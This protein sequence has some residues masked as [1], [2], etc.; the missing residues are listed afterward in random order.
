VVLLD[1]HERQFSGDSPPSDAPSTPRG[2]VEP[3]RRLRVASSL[4][5]AVLAVALGVRRRAAIATAGDGVDRIEL[6]ISPESLPFEPAYDCSAGFQNWRQGWAPHKKEWCCNHFGKGC[7][8][9]FDCNSHLDQWESK[10]SSGQKAWCC[11]HEG[12]G[13][14]IDEASK[15]HPYDCNAGFNHWK[16]GWSPFKKEYCCKQVQRG[17]EGKKALPYDC[18]AG[19][20]N[21][22]TGWANEKKKFCCQFSGKGCDPSLAKPAYDCAAGLKRW[23]V[24]WSAP[25]KKWCCEHEKRGCEPQKLPYD[26]NAGFDHWKLGWS[27]PKKA[28]CCQNAMKGCEANLDLAAP[29]PPPPPAPT[30]PPPPYDCGAGLALWREGWSAPKKAWCCKNANKGCDYDC[31]ADFDMWP[32]KWS[33]TKKKWCCANA[34]RG[35]EQCKPR[36]VPPT[37]VPQGERKT[38]AMWGDP[39]LETFD[40]SEVTFV[41]EGVFWLVKSSQVAIQGQYYAT[42]FTKGLSA[43]HDVLV[44]G[45]F[46]YNHRIKVGPMDGG[47][48]EFDGNPILWQFGEFD[49]PGGAGKVVHNAEGIPV[50]HSM[51]NLQKNVVHMW[52]PLGVYVQVMRWSNHLNV[53]ITMPP[54]AGGQDGH[55]G[56]MNNNPDDDTEGQIQQRV[57]GPV[58]NNGESLFHH[59][60]QVHPQREKLTL[61]DCDP[62]RRDEAERLCLQAQPGIV[63]E[64][65]DSCVF[66]VC[67]GGDQY[68]GEDGLEEVEATGFDCEAGYANFKTGWSTVKKEWCCEYCGRGCEPSTTPKIGIT[69]FTGTFTYT[70][71]STVTTTTT[72]ITSTSTT[73][74][75][76]STTFT[77]TTT[78]THTYTT[79]TLTTTTRT[80]ST[81]TITTTTKTTTTS[82]TRTQ[83][84]TTTSTVT[85]TT[86][87]TST[88]TTTIFHCDPQ[89]PV[90]SWSF[91]KLG[92]CCLHRGIGCSTTS[93][94]AFR[95]EG[96]PLDWEPGKQAWCCLSEKIGCATTTQALYDC[97]LGEEH[98]KCGW[99]TA[100]K[101]WCCKNA[102]KACVK[103]AAYDCSED[104]L[105][106]QTKWNNGKKAWCCI[107]VGTGCDWATST[108]PSP[109]F[110]C[111][112]GLRWVDQWSQE[113]KD[114]CCDNEDR[115]CY[116]C[117]HGVDNWEEGWSIGK[118]DW[119]CRNFNLGCVA[120]LG[121]RT[122]T[123]DE[124]PVGVSW[125]GKKA[126][127]C[128]EQAML[129]NAKLPPPYNCHDGYDAVPPRWP[130][131]WPEGKK[132]WC[133]LHEGRG[134]E[135][136][137]PTSTS[138]LLG[139]VVSSMAFDCD[140]DYSQWWKRWSELKQEHC[141]RTQGRGCPGTAPAPPP[142]PEPHPELQMASQ[143]ELHHMAMHSSS[144]A[145]APEET[146]SFD[147]DAGFANWWDGWSM[148]KKSW[149]CSKHQRGCPGTEPKSFFGLWR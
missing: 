149:C 147:C 40:R 145:I 70:Y 50:D 136:D 25:K 81:S 46:I 118:K 75:S 144:P 125:K 139:G 143:P 140:A 32:K 101:E 3:A 73:H 58:P 72:T 133:C 44:S 82:T 69:F 64:F 86:T 16:D 148:E 4:A 79:S 88:S 138:C 109:N 111:D 22:K 38:C 49:L 114:W 137:D 131:E 39:H 130:Y 116:D 7:E 119:C 57:P 34:G 102:G 80:T 92:W 120:G 89:D 95:C 2:G 76:T 11:A 100:K 126:W 60:F 24:G 17:C 122:C 108:T 123:L 21:W 54:V 48:I 35:C 18:D 77:H 127:C 47:R 97:E 37:P 103:K 56:N 74:T 67:F 112:S 20:K 8:H 61:E 42:K 29:S 10:W 31:E 68:A 105:Q 30:T 33:D 19:L 78:S 9:P 71:T 91:H 62:G 104:A 12:R 13:C 36:P 55:C 83:T 53:K 90:G 6:A 87:T 121:S 110:D 113:K 141:C 129:C 142:P 14:A 128:R 51:N 98:W 135:A 26:C 117:K 1:G 63:G 45:P 43:I 93:T 52:L 124:L 5:V 99:P 96:N 27:K 134:C 59:P 23:K 28:W 85:A 107:Y 15:A 94:A 84:T 65:L 106:W 146:A 41:A 132:A 115:A 66:D